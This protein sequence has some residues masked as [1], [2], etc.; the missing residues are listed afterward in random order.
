MASKVEEKY[1]LVIKNINYVQEKHINELF[2]KHGWEFLSEKQSQE[3]QIAQKQAENIVFRIA[4]IEGR[5]RCPYCFCQ[6]CITDESNR[7][8]W[9]LIESRDNCDRNSILRKD[10][11]R[12]FWAMM[13]HRGV[14]DIDE[15][16]RKKEQSLMD[17]DDHHTFSRER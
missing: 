17:C 16:R 12:R 15:Y 9:W 6:P 13:A 1:N 4:P 10:C 5:E 11:Y 3:A 7:Q 2:K 8:Q 14:W